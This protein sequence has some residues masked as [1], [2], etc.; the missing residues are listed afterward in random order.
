MRAP[1]QFRPRQHT[2]QTP[3]PRPRASTSDDPSHSR[4]GSNHHAHPAE[5][6]PGQHPKTSTAGHERASVHT[7]VPARGVET[8]DGAP[9]TEAPALDDQQRC[10]LGEL[11]LDAGSS[12]DRLQEARR[13]QTSADH[14]RRSQY[15]AKRPPG[16]FG[17][18]RGRRS[19]AICR[20]FDGA[21]RTRTGG[22]LGAI[23]ARAALELCRFAGAFGAH[24]TDRA[25]RNVHRLAANVH[26]LAAITGS[27]PPRIAL[28]GQTPRRWRLHSRPP[29]LTWSRTG[30][31]SASFLMVTADPALAP[32]RGTAALLLLHKGSTDAGAD[33]V[34]DR[35]C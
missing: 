22:L 3:K 35:S 2:L 32:T 7:S 5:S 9:V 6:N 16:N 31:S 29:R 10:G 23:R 4:P 19:Y 14:D 15:S 18:A 1:P 13:S 8:G 21:S 33:R 27:L 28:R 30:T 17:P 24:R 12:L 34:L 26:R 25:C 20:D 11:L